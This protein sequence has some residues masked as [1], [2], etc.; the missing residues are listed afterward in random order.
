[1]LRKQG[2][3]VLRFWEHEIAATPRVCVDRTQERLAL[4]RRQLLRKHEATK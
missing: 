1:M 4:R 3:S 2:V